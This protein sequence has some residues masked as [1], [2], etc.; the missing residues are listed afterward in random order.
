M[1]GLF[2]GTLVLVWRERVA[3][4]VNNWG[5]Q[6]FVPAQLAFVVRVALSGLVVFIFFSQG[7]RPGLKEV[8]LSALKICSRQTKFQ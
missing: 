4:A 2:A 5:T 1:F 3:V 8:A 7:F 6:L